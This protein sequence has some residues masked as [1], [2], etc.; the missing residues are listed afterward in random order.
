MQARAALGEANILID[1]VRDMEI[2][3][4]DEVEFANL[5]LLANMAHD[6]FDSR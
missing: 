2:L 5:Q 4:V 1:A 3:N 6:G